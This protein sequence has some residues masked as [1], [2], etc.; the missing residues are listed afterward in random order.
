MPLPQRPYRQQPKRQPTHTASRKPS[1]SAKRSPD[2]PHSTNPISLESAIALAYLSLA[3]DADIAQLFRE[4]GQERGR[5]GKAPL[6]RLML[7]G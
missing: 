3:S 1:P 2:G 5:R 6:L 4:A 7:L